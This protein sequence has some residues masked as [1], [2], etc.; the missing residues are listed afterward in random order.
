MSPEYH[1]L[2]LDLNIPPV[3]PRP[4]DMVLGTPH[5]QKKKTTPPSPRPG[6]MVLGGFNP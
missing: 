6:D 2:S 5:Q 4:G 3:E 1:Q